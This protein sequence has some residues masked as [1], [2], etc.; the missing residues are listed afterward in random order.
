MNFEQLC[1]ETFSTEYIKSIHKK[2]TQNILD[3]IVNFIKDS[4]NKVVQAYPGHGKTTALPLLSNLIFK[5]KQNIGLL[6]VVKEIEHMD[7]LFKSLPKRYRKVLYVN[8][9]NL[10]DV[11]KQIQQTQIVIITHARF[12]ELAVE[13]HRLG[14]LDPFTNWRGQKRY[15]IVDEMPEMFDSFIFQLT[16]QRKWM[17]DWLEANEEYT[18]V[19]RVKIRHL[20]FTAF[21]NKISKTTSIQT[22][23]PLLSEIENKDDKAI[24]EDFLA[25]VEKN[26]YEITSFKSR[27]IFRWFKKLCEKQDVGYMDKERYDN[28][29]KII[30]SKKIDYQKLGCPILILDGTAFVVKF[31]YEADYYLKSLPNW[32]LSERLNIY[33]H[34]INTSKQK[35]TNYS[36]KTYKTI[37]NEIMHLRNHGR[38][39]FI[40]AYKD[41]YKYYKQEGL[42]EEDDPLYDKINIVTTASKNYLANYNDLYLGAL[43]ILPPAQY[44]AA[45]IALYADNQ[46]P[47]DLGM[48]LV[49]GQ[50]FNDSRI[51]KVYLSFVL[52]EIIQIIYRSNIRNLSEPKD[53]KVNIYI[54]TKH[55]HLLN[56]L[57]KRFVEIGMDQ[58]NFYF[59]YTTV[60]QLSDIREKA[61]KHAQTIHKAIH[62]KQIQLPN[63]IGKIKDNP[64]VK[65]FVNRYWRKHP[66]PIQDAFAEQGL[67]FVLK[68]NRKEIDWLERES[69]FNHK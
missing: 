4:K 54:A 33:H 29:Q 59:H 60:E 50:W 52:R 66:E 67:K 39:P 32:T 45:A 51:E 30:C 8:N 13:H 47:L 68:S 9:E 55:V 65:N 26:I 35:R 22:G 11:W 37:S 21:K 61:N 69:S 2:A 24:L 25:T 43:P 12:Q 5:E 41:D 27:S 19:D 56:K 63:P 58:V 40:L 31:L 15:I 1:N 23:E 46:R 36:R 38:D 6:F 3:E 16:D 18:H 64:T 57:Q 42:I 14:N 10:S 34:N 17:N 48:N 28:E 53:S 62:D 44:K 20:V 7:S 49:Q